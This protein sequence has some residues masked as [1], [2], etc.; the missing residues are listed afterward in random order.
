MPLVHC[1]QC[2]KSFGAKPGRIASGRAKFCSRECAAA[3]RRL[4]RTIQ[5]EWC[6]KPVPQRKA[7]Q[8]FCSRAC[9]ASAAHAATHGKPPTHRACRTCGATFTPANHADLHCSMQ[10][11]ISDMQGRGGN[12]LF[13]DPWASGAIPPDRYG[14]D[15]YRTPDVWLGF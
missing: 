5:C 9:A 10:C 13:E 14:K 3:A 2:G 6:H 15:L 8:R 12:G 1:R 7:M 11:R 4:T